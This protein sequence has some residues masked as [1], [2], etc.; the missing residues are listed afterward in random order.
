M[1][2]AILV[3]IVKCH[4]MDQKVMYNFGNEY[5]ALITFI[6]LNTVKKNDKYQNV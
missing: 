5:R 3:L 2:L 1:M 6:S 4:T